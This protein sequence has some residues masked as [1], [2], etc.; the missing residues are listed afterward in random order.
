[1]SLKKS[2]IALVLFSAFLTV[3][4]NVMAR[5]ISCDYISRSEGITGSTDLSEEFEVDTMNFVNYDTALA[6]KKLVNGGV[7]TV[8]AAKDGKSGIALSII[9]K[10]GE[11]IAT[12]SIEI[13]GD[14]ESKV[15]LDH[16]KKKSLLTGGFYTRAVCK[17]IN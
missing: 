14:L 7:L 8:N 10:N 13:D 4:S 2:F 3:S 15:R 9:L 17:Y 1:M 11:V 6:T 5:T 16:V 12:Q